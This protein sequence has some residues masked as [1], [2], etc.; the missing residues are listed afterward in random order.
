VAGYYVC[1]MHVSI[2]ALD[3]ALLLMDNWAHNRRTE[4]RPGHW[5]HILSPRNLPG[6]PLYPSWTWQVVQ[7]EHGQL[8]LRADGLAEQLVLTQDLA[9]ELIIFTPS[10]RVFLADYLEVLSWYRACRWG[11]VLTDRDDG[12]VQFNCTRYGSRINTRAVGAI[13]APDVVQPE[14]VWL[15]MLD[16]LF[17]L[18]HPSRAD[19]LLGNGE[20]LP[21]GE[22]DRFIRE[23]RRKVAK[24]AAA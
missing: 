19:A 20:H 4:L 17:S 14:V 23:M 10:E 24:M 22:R 16:A 13:P 21:V 12:W 11:L 15:H 3:S 9:D 1:F 18:A 7:G 5:L 6:D 8:M 2:D